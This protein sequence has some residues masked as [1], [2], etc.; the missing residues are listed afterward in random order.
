MKICTAEE[1]REL[2][3][4]TIE[5][6]GIPGVVLMENAGLHIVRVIRERYPDLHSKRLL[7]VCGKGNNGGDGFVV[8]RHVFNQEID[9]QV[10][11]LTDKHKVKGDA[12]GNLDIIEK[13]GIP[14]EEIASEEQMPAFLN[15][16]QQAD[17]VVDAILGTGLNEAVRGFY[18]QI[19][20]SLNNAGKPVVAVDI[21]S[22]LHANSC[23]VPGRCIRADATVTFAAAKRALVMYPAAE[24]V[25][26]LEV[27]DISIPKQML[28]HSDIQVNILEAAEVRKAFPPRD[29]N[30]HK[31]TYG[32]VLV[33]AGSPGKSGA[34]MMT[35]NSALRSGAG[36][37]T[38][39]IP[40]SLNIPLEIATFEVMTVSLP[41]TEN[42]GISAEACQD[43]MA[44]SDKKQ[45]AAIGPGLSTHP[46]T[47][48]LVHNLISGLAI[49]MVIDADGIN[50]IA[51]QPD[52]LLQANAPIIVTP[53]PGEMARLA[54]GAHIQENRIDVAQETARKYNVFLVLKGIRTVVASPD[55]DVYI[56][57]T[58]N[59][60]MATGGTGD[61]LTGVIAG[62]LAQ[63]MTPLDAATT[64]VFLHG[65]AGDLAA[66][67]KGEYGLIAGDLM[68][69]IPAAIQR[70]QGAG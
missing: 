33:V 42:G 9:V 67:E 30:T 62:L 49:P 64:G 22:G 14:I 25:G 69:T 58:G 3:R 4:K 18:K 21:P 26:D 54:P 8:A 38:V 61:V 53:H 60:G 34:A 47:V 17:I 55:G 31:G 13:M 29:P 50:A 68:N 44:A 20:E 45:A 70:V 23:V 12:R 16:L 2:D 27:V 6:V 10:A 39:A 32:H 24:Y 1:V 46:S 52:V 19:I 65:L 48:E 51:Q 37:V 57:P 56:N 5:D 35:G 43:I 7:I 63:G 41:E 11:L 66:E 36:L 28:D 59:P 15:L 40:A